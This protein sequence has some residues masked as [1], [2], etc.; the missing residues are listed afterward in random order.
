MFN[1]L[2]AALLPYMPKKL[3][4]I[5]SKK[6]IA[7]E[8]LAQAIAT[9]K[10]LNDEGIV[11]TIDVLGEFIKNLDEAKANKDE[12]LEVVEQAEKNGVK[13]NFLSNLL[14]LD[15][16]STKKSAINMFVRWWQKL[17]RITILCG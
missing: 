15:C 7:G 10:K 9:S 12:Y 17:L 6:Y 14:F 11:V 3:V 13:G 16:C 1:K 4:W 5:F 8:T 2:I